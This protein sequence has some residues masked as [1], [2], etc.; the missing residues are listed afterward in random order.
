VGKKEET[1]VPFDFKY[2]K[3][4]EQIKK[5]EKKD[6]S[7]EKEGGEGDQDENFDVG[8]EQEKIDEPARESEK[9]APSLAERS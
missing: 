7:F 8:D 4:L 3:K 1:F 6:D 5:K 2:D 9:K